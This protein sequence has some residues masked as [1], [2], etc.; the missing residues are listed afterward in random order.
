MCLDKML[1]ELW[2]A[3]TGDSTHSE[4]LIVDAANGVGASKLTRLQHLTTSLGLQVRNSGNEGGGLLNDGVGVDFV[5]KE[6]V[7]PHGFQ[8]PADVGKR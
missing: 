2:H 3:N 1:V 8:L 4:E 5:Q 6:K 7:L